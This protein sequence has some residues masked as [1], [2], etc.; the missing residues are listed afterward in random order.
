[1]GTEL[2]LYSKGTRVWVKDPETVWKPAQVT[3][4]FDGSKL[5]L[6][7][8]DDA[9]QLELQIG[10]KK[11]QEELPPLRNPDILIGEND[12]TSL[13]YLHEPAVL[14]N[15]A[16]R[17]LDNQAIYTYCGIVLVAIN[18]YEEL[19]IYGNETISMYRGK[20]MG[21][22]DPHIYAVSEEAFTKMERYVVICSTHH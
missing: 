15:L 21:E 19:P 16:V 8:E 1:M 17:F 4:D 13:S 12:L 20:N 7:L 6:E 22:L 18:P 11:G 14:H 2:K 9:T 10:D 3:K 5:L